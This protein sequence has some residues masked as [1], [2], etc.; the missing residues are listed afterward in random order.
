MVRFVLT[1]FTV[2]G[3]FLG[4]VLGQSPASKIL[5]VYGGKSFCYRGLR[6]EVLGTLETPKGSAAFQLQIKG[7]KSRLEIPGEV[8]LRDGMLGQVI[9]E[10]NR[11]SEAR[12]IRHGFQEAALLPVIL[13]ARLEDYQF[14]GRSEKMYWFSS[15]I[16]IK[17][18]LGYDPPPPAVFLGFHSET[19][20]LQTARF[21]DKFKQSEIQVRYSDYKDIHG[22]P[23][24]TM[25][26][27]MEGN[28]VFHRFRIQSVKVNPD[29]ADSDLDIVTEGGR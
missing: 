6:L 18:F 3:F 26:E 15:S 29:F 16:P 28:F 13:V 1:L 8:F 25:I 10:G 4:L 11:K 17:R 24:P 21:I 23:F 14:E 22:V 27:R 20:R 7:E 12:W 9:M 2:T 19:L 5:D